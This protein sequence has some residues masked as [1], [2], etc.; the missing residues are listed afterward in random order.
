M[1]IS[2]YTTVTML[3]SRPA[4][5]TIS[6]PKSTDIT[7]RIITFKDLYG[8][9]SNSTIAL[10][11][12]SGDTFEDGTVSTILSNAYQTVNLYAGQPGKWL[13]IGATGGGSSAGLTTVSNLLNSV[14]TN[15][16]TISTNLDT[17][18][19]R[20]NGV[21]TNVTTISTNLNTVSNHLNSLSTNLITIS[22]NLDT[23]SNR[24]NGVSTN[25]ITIS[26]NLD[27]VS[28]RLN[29]VSTNVTTIS[30]N[31]D[32]VSNR[33]NGVSTNVITISTNLNTVSNHLNAV[34]T[35]VIT[36][37]TNLNTVSNHLNAVSTNVITT[38]TNLNSIST[39]VAAGRFPSISTNTISSSLIRTGYISS[40]QG[41]I[42]SLVVD[43]LAFSFSNSFIVM[44]DI[45]TTS[46]STIQTFTSSLTTN[47]LRVGTVSS[48]SFISFPGL[49]QGYNQG[50]IAEQS[51]GTG[52]QELLVFRGSSASDRIRMQTTGSIVFEPGVGARV[53]PTAGSN[54]T[55]AM[56]INTSSNVGIGTAAP[57]VTLDVVGAG[58]FTAVSTNTIS[59]NQVNSGNICNAGWISNS[60][61]LS[62]L[63]GGAFF[64]NTS[65]TGTL[66]VAGL[67]TLTNI[68]NSGV[69]SNLT[70]GAFFQNTSNTGTLGVGGILT[71]ASNITQTGGTTVLAGLSVN[72]ISTNTI[73]GNMGRFT[74]ISTNTISTN[75]VNAGYLVGLLPGNTAATSVSPLAA[76]NGNAYLSFSPQ[77]EFQYNSGGYKHF[78]GSRHQGDTANS[79][80][81]AV[82]FWLYSATTGGS[83][84]ST[85][86]G[87]CNVNTMSVTAQGV[88]IFNNSPSLAL[89]VTG[90]GRFTGVST[91][92]ISTNTINGNI[93]RFTGV[94]TNTISTNIV[95]ANSG[96]FTGVSTNTISTNIVNAGYL[97]GLLPGTNSITSVSP[98][99]LTN[100]SAPAASAPQIEFQN[101][102]S[103]GLNHFMGS[104]HRTNELNSASNSIDFWLYSASSG[105]NTASTTPGT[106]NVN[107]MSVTA[108][109]VG[110][111]TNAPSVGLDVAGTGRFQILST[112]QIYVSSIS[113]GSVYG[114]FFGDGSS[115]TGLPS[116]GSGGLPIST[117]NTT[118]TDSASIIIKTP[119]TSYFYEDYTNLTNYITISDYG[120]QNGDYVNIVNTG[121][122]GTPATF[123]VL[124]GSVAASTIIRYIYPGHAGVVAYSSSQWWPL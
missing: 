30:T 86:P 41:Y 89:D 73:N 56:I 38:S 60:G 45:I 34:S 90:A 16:T 31:L 72:T 5:I 96:S 39:I 119:N 109:G 4:P 92:T 24:L 46:V 33:L 71:A 117:N 79:F 57:G 103:G 17:V 9:A 15:V 48:L 47:N 93:G 21:S 64:Q 27:T 122:S 116:G 75:I 101:N 2:S 58:R 29:G 107:T 26:T 67:A 100:G 42:S 97:V 69:L 83:N 1:S 115:L 14:S 53:F 61:V 105:G 68:S 77:I 111:F 99:A 37:S 104:R 113:S 19:N 55:P 13:N 35:N 18:S 70:G 54:V 12:Q 106:C 50:V 74:G 51:T 43:S 32:T 84:A 40:P 36:I 95:N 108:A 52:L 7:N 80:G 11:T 10:V 23:V 102:T 65:N 87:T 121:N 91:N 120:A 114:K 59:T 63:T 124:D 78:M 3:D 49:Q 8:S 81:N 66:G 88:G 22:T 6:V 94:S 25:V 20:L 82:D 28:N 112:Q 123:Q 98:L 62:N 118:L 110:I 85:T 44:G 76:T